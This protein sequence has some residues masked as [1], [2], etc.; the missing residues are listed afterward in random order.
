MLKGMDI[1]RR[2]DF[3]PTSDKSEPKTVFVLKPLSS[4]DATIFTELHEK[5]QKE[6]LMFY[7]ENSIVEIKNFEKTNIKEAIEILDGQTL[8]ELLTEINKINKVSG[9]EIK[10]S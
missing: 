8:G 1:N 5:S 7:I 4:L 2:I 3:I 6:S 9:Q 10:N